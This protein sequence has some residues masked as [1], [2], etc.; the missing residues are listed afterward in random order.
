MEIL[1]PTDTLGIQKLYQAFSIF[2]KIL[3]ESTALSIDILP[4]KNRRSRKNS[5]M[6]SPHSVFFL[7]KLHQ[8]SIWF[9]S[10]AIIMTKKD[11][12]NVSGVFIVQLDIVQAAVASSDKGISHPRLAVVH[13]CFLETL[14][15]CFKPYI[16][17]PF[18]KG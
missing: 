4:R 15:R 12:K 10:K 8:V 6:A 11:R 1:P 5:L 2:S 18:C 17:A 3:T 16:L 14:G 7:I 9:Q 13:F